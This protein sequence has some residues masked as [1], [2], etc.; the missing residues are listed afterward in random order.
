VTRS[1]AAESEIEGFPDLRGSAALWLLVLLTV[2]V[3]LP[4]INRP[5]VGNFATKNVVYAMIARNWAEGRTGLAYPMLDCLVGGQ[6]SLHMLEWPISAYLSGGLWRAF[7]GSLDVWGRATSVAFS[8]AAVALLFLFVRRRHS[9]A[10]AVGVGLA[11]ALAPV[12][13]LCGQSF[14]LEPSL[15]FFTVA[16]FYALD[17]WLVGGRRPWLATAAAAL[18]LVLLTK[19]YMLVLLL[20]LATMVLFPPRDRAASRSSGLRVGLT[21]AALAVAMVPAAFW[22]HHA[23]VTV[24]GGPLA[25]RVFYSVRQSVS[26]HSI[27]HA[28]LASADFWKQMLDDA[29]TVVLTPIGFS[30][31]LAGVLNRRWR[32]HAAWLAASVFLMLALPRKFYE[33]N[34]YWMAV[35][36]PLCIMVGLGWQ[37]VWERVKPG[38][39]AAAGLLVVAL[40]FSLRYAA[41]PA[42]ITPDEDRAVVAAGEAV[43]KLTAPGEPV[44]TMHGS[45]IDLVYYCNRPGWAVAP[46]APELAR[47]LDDCRRR[48]ARYLVVAGPAA[49][50]PPAA[51]ESL[52]AIVRG[53]GFAV[54]SLALVGRLP[55]AGADR[56]A[57][58]FHPRG[59]G[60]MKH[61]RL[62]VD[63]RRAGSLHCLHPSDR[64]HPP[65][66]RR[67]APRQRTSMIRKES[68]DGIGYSVVELN[69]VRHVYAAAVPRVG[70]NMKAQAE[71]ALSTIRAVIEEEGTRG[72]IVQ[73][74]VFMSDAKHLNCCRGLIEKFYGDEL[75]ATSYIFQPPCCGKLLSI[76]ALGVGRGLGEVQIQRISDQLVVTTHSDISWV[77]AAQIVPDTPSPCV[78]ERSLSAFAKMK[79]LLAS[80]G[81]R[82][83]Q[84]I[85]TWLYLGDIVGP[86]GNTQRYKEL[87]R[88][89]TDFF[90]GICFAPDLVLPGFDGVVYPASTGIGTDDRDV[91][92]SCIALVTDRRDIVAVPLENPRQT[93]A[94]AY[95]AKYSPKS[96][97]FSRA[98]ALSCG[99][100]ATVLVSGTASITNA[101]TRHVGDIEGQT[102]ETLDNIEALISPANLA[103]HGMP[104][105]G[106]T[107]EGL[108]LVRVYIK[109]QEDYAKCRAVCEARLGELPTVYAVADVC[110]PELLVEIEGIAFSQ[111]A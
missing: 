12:S 66:S 4:A 107:L 89:R 52:D 75:P 100:Y 92:M 96:P 60:G 22:Y 31:A 47:L 37:V 80:R 68:S 67:E 45:T 82:F 14:M 53:D 69:D 104:G 19:I 28:M 40:V 79:D 88:A 111:R 72:S 39:T 99:P 35:L 13:I 86:E 55:T 32:Q 30:L 58:I 49:A 57:A 1:P 91:A 48:G 56:R 74:A 50:A 71:D 24:P 73:Q 83:D 6:R 105:L 21:L 101:E 63:G 25:D 7:G 77:H 29:A 15:V 54:Y 78:Y 11:L 44:V 85:R 62:L 70:G 95:A 42:F 108:A 43:Q 34:Y 65:A 59:G 61:P 3:R 23:L 103:A 97:K 106:T 27:T 76:E 81:V 109:R 17:R 2:A 98:M 16:T 26:A 38:R 94:F 33:M 5:L 46:D 84:V 102:R 64:S 36:P 110:R 8:G 10:A 41:K 20:P 87:N 90:D 93:S 9:P 18:A 51:L